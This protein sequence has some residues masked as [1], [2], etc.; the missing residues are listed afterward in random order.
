M[1][2]FITVLQWLLG[3]ASSAPWNSH[4]N[5]NPTSLD[6]SSGCCGNRI[7]LQYWTQNA[8]VGLIVLMLAASSNPLKKWPPF[9]RMPFVRKFECNMRWHRAPEQHDLTHLSPSVMLLH[10]ISKNAA[11]LSYPRSRILNVRERAFIRSLEPGFSSV[12]RVFIVN[13]DEGWWWTNNLYTFI[14]ILYIFI[15]SQVSPKWR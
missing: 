14:Y 10:T 13:A 9:C 1:I 2:Y 3:C 11:L 15:W 7:I 6:F 8:M 4:T 12:H 5:I